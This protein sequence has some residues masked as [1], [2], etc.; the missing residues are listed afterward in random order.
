MIADFGLSKQLT[1]ETTS[2]SV[3]Y[4]MPEY[5]EPQFYKNDNY[6]RDKNSDIYSLVFSYGKY[7]V[8]I[9]PFQQF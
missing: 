2:N 7:Q 6:M 8:D 9:L 4:K 1:V 3:V 5:V